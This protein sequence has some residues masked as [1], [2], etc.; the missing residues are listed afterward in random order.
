MYWRVSP[1]EL[2]K[3]ERIWL[4]A[5]LSI[6]S[7]FIPVPIPDY[8]LITVIEMASVNKYILWSRCV[9]LQRVTGD[10]PPKVQKHPRTA[11]LSYIDVSATFCLPY[12]DI[13]NL[14]H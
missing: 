1:I 4:F 7:S 2:T 5:L 13:S 3:S 12:I 14:I 8:P 9:A 11:N 10:F 6:V